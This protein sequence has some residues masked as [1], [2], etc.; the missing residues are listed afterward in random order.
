MWNGLFV[1]QYEVLSVHLSGQN[2]EN[3][4]NLLGWPVFMSKI[5]AGNSQLQSKAVEHALMNTVKVIISF[6]NKKFVVFLGSWN[7]I[8]EL[9]HLLQHKWCNG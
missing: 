9:Q 3:C 1:A 2:E 6:H 7:E 4:E 5:K 8:T